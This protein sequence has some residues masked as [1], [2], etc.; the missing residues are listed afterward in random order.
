MHG[1]GL[2]DEGGVWGELRW[3]TAVDANVENHRGFILYGVVG[4]MVG[5]V[6]IRVIG[7]GCVGH[8]GVMGGSTGGW[9]NHGGHRW[10]RWGLIR[11]G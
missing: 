7:S 10:C 3:V 8:L 4:V 6:M 11:E 1:G 2:S 5:G 9:C